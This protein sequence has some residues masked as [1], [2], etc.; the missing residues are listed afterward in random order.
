MRI[1]FTDYEMNVEFIDPIPTSLDEPCCELIVYQGG[2]ETSRR[3]LS[4]MDA[5]DLGMSVLAFN[6]KL[7]DA[8]R[9]VDHPNID[10]LNETFTKPAELSLATWKPEGERS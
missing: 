6:R 8:V 7:V 4:A 3:P 9:R 1:V 2:Q 5:N 10:N